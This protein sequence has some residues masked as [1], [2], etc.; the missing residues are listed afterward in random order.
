[1]ILRILTCSDRFGKV[2]LRPK[3]LTCAAHVPTITVAREFIY[4]IALLKAGSTSFLVE[5][6]SH[7]VVKTTRDLTE[8]YETSLTGNTKVLYH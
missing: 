8:E 4:N 1:M 7:L 5:G 3:P 2:L 6:R